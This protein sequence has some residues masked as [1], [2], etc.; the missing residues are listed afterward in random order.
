MSDSGAP[1]IAGGAPVR[2]TPLP[3]GR[4]Q[5]TDADRAAVLAAL[6]SGMLTGGSAVTRF[7]A[8]LAERCGAAHAVAVCNGTAALHVALAALGCNDGDEVI[9]SPLTF[10]A[11]ANAALFCG[12]TP[13]FA[14]IGEDRNLDP[15]AAAAKTTARTCA[16]V[17]VDY[18]GLP[19]D[20]D[21][22]RAAL[23]AGCSVVADAAHSL[24]GS[25]RGR[26]VGSLADVTTCSFHPVKQITTGEGGACLT[27]DAGLAADMR[28]LRNHGMTSEAAAR[29]GRSWR[30]DV[31]ELGYNYRITD[32]QAALGWSQLR[33]LDEIVARR[34]ELADRYD[35]LISAIPGVS[36]PPRVADRRSAWHIYAIEI[37]AH[38]FGWS[39]DSVID[40]LRAENIQATLHYPA[41]HLLSMY[42]E[43]GHRPGE[44]P[45][46]ERVC[47]RLVTLP[48]FTSMTEADQDD[49]VHALTRVA[50]WR[51]AVVA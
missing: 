24:G 15:A 25:V 6:D 20:V 33:R 27:D 21:V 51:P 45:I 36:T 2:T 23:P 34:A 26:P 8:A 40:A 48:L 39:R 14:D 43:R 4:H 18:G 10:V 35:S 41:A 1:A 3:Y 37:D 16:V 13:V 22:L 5:L 32:L 12:A 47:E 50:A 11:S 9:T 7:E 31:T 29:T 30:Y 38:A 46:A 44:A 19:D 17:A 28:R 42:R 49:V